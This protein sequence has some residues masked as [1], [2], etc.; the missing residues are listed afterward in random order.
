MVFPLI[1]MLANMV[2]DTNFWPRQIHVGVEDIHNN[3]IRNKGC[4]SINQS[5][6]AERFNGY[7]A[8]WS[9]MGGGTPVRMDAFSQ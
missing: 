6:I 7:C 9:R 8:P 2:Q 5:P 3:Q 1:D 4:H